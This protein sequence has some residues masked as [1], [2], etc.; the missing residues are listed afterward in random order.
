M[1]TL[2]EDFEALLGWCSV[3]K[4][5]KMMELASQE[6][7]LLSVELGVYGGRSLLPL[8]LATSWKKKGWVV[9][10][11]AW[12]APASVEG[13]NTSETTSYWSKIDYNHVYDLA[14][15]LMKKH[16]V[17]QYVDLWRSRS[18]D[19]SE[20]FSN[21]SIDLLHQDGNHSEEISCKEVELYFT[22]LRR[23]GYWIFD[24]T[25]W[26]STQAAQ[27]LLLEK[28]FSE[29]FAEEGGTWKIFQKN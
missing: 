23:G 7:V 2:P 15:S 28:G 27:Q 6:D 16:Q 26:P 25:H 11:D 13:T 14:S 8:A 29:I 24:D 21:G 22:K 9:G 20:L 19:V 12:C 17:E 3:Q 5:L 10:I 18:E 4:G 1:A